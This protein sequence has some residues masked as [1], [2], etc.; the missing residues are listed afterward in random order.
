MRSVGALEG[1]GAK[2]AT[3]PDG[4]SSSIHFGRKRRA[5]LA[6]MQPAT[7]AQ[8]NHER[9]R[10]RLKPLQPRDGDKLATRGERLDVR[11]IQDAERGLQDVDLLLGVRV[12]DT[13]RL[14]GV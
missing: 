14:E 11:G 8:T 12:S 2:G 7:R 6:E 4:A 5:V 13:G 9:N 10:G 3:R 1:P